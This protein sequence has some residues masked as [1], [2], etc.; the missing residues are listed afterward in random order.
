MNTYLSLVGLRLYSFI[1]ASFNLLPPVLPA[2]FLEVENDVSP[3]RIFSE[4]TPTKF[5]GFEDLLAWGE[6]FSATIPLFW[7][8]IQFLAVLPFYGETNYLKASEFGFR[9]DFC[10]SIS[11]LAS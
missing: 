10:L 4:L 1:K 7:I 6:P 5:I 8:L 11:G 2:V 3:L 9:I